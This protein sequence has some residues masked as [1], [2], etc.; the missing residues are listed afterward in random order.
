MTPETAPQSSTDRRGTLTEGQDSQEPSDWQ[1]R[2]AAARKAAMDRKRAIRAAETPPT[3]R[4]TGYRPGDRV[5]T[6]C[7]KS[8]R[9]H[10]RDGTVITSSLGE[11]GVSFTKQT[12]A[13]EAWF[14]PSELTRVTA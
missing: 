2:A 3:R 13:S 5:H 8:P 6:N 12:D 4:D 10:D 11:V 7:P 14:L 1:P 9:F